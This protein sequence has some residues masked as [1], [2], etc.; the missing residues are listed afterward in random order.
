MRNINDHPITDDEKRAALA[1]AIQLLEATTTPG[2]MRPAALRSLAEEIAVENAPEEVAA[3]IVK[4]LDWHLG[5]WWYAKTI[6]GI[7]EFK[8]WNVDPS[9]PAWL[10]MPGERSQKACRNIDEA[11]K[12]AQHHFNAAILSVLA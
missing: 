5:N 8:N 1:A 2:D 7:Y 11:R 4:G 12:V 6:T 9:G 3:R 10:S